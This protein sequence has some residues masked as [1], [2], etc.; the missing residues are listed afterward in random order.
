VAGTAVAIGE[1]ESHR[2]NIWWSSFVFL[3]L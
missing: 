1:L 3:M 2:A